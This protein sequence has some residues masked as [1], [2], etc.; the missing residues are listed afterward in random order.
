M[1]TNDPLWGRDVMGTMVVTMVEVVVMSYA[2]HGSPPAAPAS[3]AMSSSSALYM[4]GDTCRG[5]LMYL[6]L[7][8]GEC[9]RGNACEK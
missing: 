2:V 5:M 1:H 6:S 8:E 7:Q 3:L 9:Q 4:S